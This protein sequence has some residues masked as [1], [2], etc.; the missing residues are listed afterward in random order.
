M[1]QAALARFGAVLHGRRRLED[2][3]LVGGVAAHENETETGWCRQR[4]VR[5]TVR[6]EWSREST[7]SANR[8]KKGFPFGFSPRATRIEAAVTRGGVK[9]WTRWN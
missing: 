2:G 6:E 4:L 1:E 3:L 5:R 9:Q 8:R 7:T